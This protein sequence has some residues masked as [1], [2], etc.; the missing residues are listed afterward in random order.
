VRK[1]AIASC[2]LIR[3]VLVLF[4]VIAALTITGY[5][6]AACNSEGAHFPMSPMRAIR[7]NRAARRIACMAFI[8][9]A[10]RLFNKTKRYLRNPARGAFAEAPRVHRHV[11]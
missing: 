1:I 7:K 3:V 9:S 2:G 4:G 10:S 6:H 11:Q 5:R 8:A